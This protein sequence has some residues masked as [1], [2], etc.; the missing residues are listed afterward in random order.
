L[1]QGAVTTSAP[2][3]TT[4]KT[5]PLSLNTS[6][7]LRVDGSG[8]TQPVS[9]TFWQATQP[10]SGSV[11]VTQ[12]TG[13]NL[14]AVLDTTST[15][16]VT[17]ATASN[18]NAAVVGVGTA[19]SPSGGILTVQ[20][21][22]S[23]TKLLVTPDSVA[24]PANQSVNM[25][26]I[27]GTAVL[28]DPCQANT[29]VYTLINVT[30]GTQLITGTSAKKQYICALQLVTATAQNIAIVEGTG[31]VCATSTLGLLGGP[32]AATGWNL[33][34]NGGLTYG[35][36]SSAL[37]ATTVNANNVCILTSSSG[38]ISGNIVSVAQ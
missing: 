10:V 8:V 30:T 28:A 13:T 29:K 18:L 4:A 11:T 16:A 35:N 38:Q 6:G 25:S 9:G 37:A 17:Q 5:N 27:G 24:L 12:A 20:G 19:G 7:G 32:S 33:V 2:T 3:Y 14:H 15:T 21:V 23:M 31:T 22:A 36:G 26:Q 1:I 34:A